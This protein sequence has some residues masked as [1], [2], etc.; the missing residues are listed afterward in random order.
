VAQ[1]LPIN[2]G[3]IAIPIEVETHMLLTA[4][5]VRVTAASGTGEWR[6]YEDRANASATA[7]E[8]PGAN[9]TLAAQAA[10]ATFASTPTTNPVYLAPG[11][12]W[13]VI[14]CT[15]A[16]V[17]FSLGTAAQ[18]T[19]TAHGAVTKTLAAV[20]GATLDLVT[21]WTAANICPGVRLQGRVLG[22]ASAF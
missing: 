1:V 21:T 19:I 10:A 5:A 2:G 16:T 3:S 8:I 22:Q 11:V 4:I 13:L 12:Y 14:R 17:T 6:L 9:G 15:S 7:N 18:G 20:L